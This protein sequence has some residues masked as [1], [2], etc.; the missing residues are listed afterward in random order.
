MKQS[1]DIPLGNYVTSG[2]TLELVDVF[3]LACLFEGKPVTDTFLKLNKK[4]ID[5]IISPYSISWERVKNRLAA[6][7]KLGYVN[8]KL[9]NSEIELIV[10]KNAEKLFNGLKVDELIVDK[11]SEFKI[12]ESDEDRMY[13][14]WLI[15][16]AMPHSTYVTKAKTDQLTRR[17]LIRS[18]HMIRKTHEKEDVFHAI[19]FA[20]SDEFWRK[21]FL[22]PLKLEQVQKSSGIKYIDLFLS[23]RN[24]SKPQSSAPANKKE[25]NSRSLD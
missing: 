11:Q 6:M 3:I 25:N 12:E 2:S 24:A 13:L 14:S 19:K 4:A 1:I 20:T 18:Y 17:S 7:N 23:L 9:N 15:E 22:S 16:K 10:L 5:R 8:Y 21:N